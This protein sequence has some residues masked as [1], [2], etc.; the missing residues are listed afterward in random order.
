VRR[1]SLCIV[2]TV[3]YSGYTT[4]SACVSIID[5]CWQRSC[6]FDTLRVQTVIM[7]IRTIT[8]IYS[9]LI[10]IANTYRVMRGRSRISRA[11]LRQFR[12]DPKWYPRHIRAHGSVSVTHLK[13]KKIHTLVTH[14]KFKMNVSHRP[15]Q[16]LV[17]S[18]HIAAAERERNTLVLSV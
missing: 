16:L 5:I 11:S 17:F 7:P 15:R 1:D 14:V 2:M 18:S 3:R 13:V 8:T 6:P 9:M 10:I 12:Q 4:W